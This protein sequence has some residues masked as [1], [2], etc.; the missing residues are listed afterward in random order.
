[1]QQNAISLQVA[2]SLVLCTFMSAP[3][4]YVSARMVLITYATEDQYSHII[5][6]TQKDV[7]VVTCICVVRMHT[8]DVIIHY[9]NI[10][11]PVLLL[12][13]H[14]FQVWVFMLFLLA[15][16]YRSYAH[17]FVMH[18]M[19]AMVSSILHFPIQLSI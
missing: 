8:L 10:I 2:A 4:M 6:D 7:T 5:S 15:R 16:R 9:N 1:M 18:L 12:F 11:L 19:V 3:I 17:V 13:Y 14:S